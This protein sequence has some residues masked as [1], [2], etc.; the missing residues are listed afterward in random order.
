MATSS[1][2]LWQT[3]AESLRQRLA[4]G[5]LLA[6]MRLTS[7]QSLAREWRTSR[8]TVR[9]ALLSL[10]EVGLLRRRA[11]QGWFVADRQRRSTSQGVIAAIGLGPRT[12]AR[13]LLAD[14]DYDLIDYQPPL[15]VE[16]VPTPALA[17]ALCADEHIRAVMILSMRAVDTEFLRILRE[18]QRPVAVVGLA[19][20]SGCDTVACDFFGASYRLVHRAYASG[21]RR[22]ALYGRHLHKELSPFRARIDGYLAATYALGISS[23]VQIAPGSLYQR[24]DL[25]EWYAARCM[26]EPID[27]CVL[28]VAHTADVVAALHQVRSIPEDLAIAG[29]GNDAL[30]AGVTLPVPALDAVYEPWEDVVVTA[31]RR[32]LAR[33]DGDDTRPTLSL[34]ACDLIAGGSG[35]LGNVEGIS[36]EAK[37]AT[38]R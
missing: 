35:F 33:L 16:T 20:A 23:M 12:A 10:A 15:G 11:G 5:S 9:S 25:A 32:L 14:H 36:A 28:D 8:Q 21:R 30:P 7:E 17:A 2:P 31:A 27:A 24:S 26:A 4:S 19:E 34:V 3:I 18:Q 38:E 22:L 6:G 13:T 37:R 1:G 29:Y